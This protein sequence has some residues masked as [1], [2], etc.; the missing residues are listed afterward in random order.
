MVGVGEE[1]EISFGPGKY[2]KQDATE[3]LNGG[4]ENKEFRAGFSVEETV[5]WVAV[6]TGL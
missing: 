1:G 3:V 2:W 6:V 5:E 4:P